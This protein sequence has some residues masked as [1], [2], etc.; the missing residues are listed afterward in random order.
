[1]NSG[2]L[3]CTDSK[4]VVV[5]LFGDALFN[6]LD[7]NISFIVTITF[8]DSSEDSMVNFPSL[9]KAWEDEKQVI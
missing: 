5:L 8:I 1:M 7:D 9:S 3:G 2:I 6:Q 4:L